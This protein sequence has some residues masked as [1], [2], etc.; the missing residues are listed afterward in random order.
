M[1][2]RVMRT[3]MLASG[4]LALALTAPALADTGPK[5]VQLTGEVID[6]W[7]QLSGIMG[8]ALGTA[9]HQ[10]AIWCAIGGVPVGLQGDDGSAYILIRV[11]NEVANAPSPTV[12]DM[13]T[14]RI[15]VDGNLY[16]R[17]G[18]KYLVV[19]KVLA[20]EGIVNLTHKDSGIIPFGE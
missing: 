6:T 9:H 2:W 13:Q 17:D 8:M 20:N 15:K 14:D 11:E 10:C 7:C 16:E 4:L 5:R 18:V 12:V 3:T 1:R 19:S